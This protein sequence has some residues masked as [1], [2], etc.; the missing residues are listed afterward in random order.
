MIIACKETID[1]GTELYL[2][3]QVLCTVPLNIPMVLADG[4]GRPDMISGCKGEMQLGLFYS[5]S[6]I[7]NCAKLMARGLCTPSRAC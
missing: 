4:L 2:Y 5:K 3:K 1:L 6:S 7:H